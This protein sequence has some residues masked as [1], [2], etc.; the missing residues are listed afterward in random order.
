MQHFEF[1]LSFIFLYIADV[2]VLH[3]YGV[4]MSFSYTGIMQ[5]LGS[6]PRFVKMV[7]V[8]PRDGLQ[9]EKSIVPTA[10]KVYLIKMLISSGLSVVVATSFVSTKCVPQVT[11]NILIA[12]HC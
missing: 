7:E 4:T 11:Y 1:T 6:I 10:V 12:Y 9:N 3:F 8:G 5:F 2:F